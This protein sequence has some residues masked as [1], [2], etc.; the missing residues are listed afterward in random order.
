M[1]IRDFNNYRSFGVIA[2][3]QPMPGIIG[4]MSRGAAN[5]AEN[6]QPGFAAAWGRAKI[7]SNNA[8]ALPNDP[9]AQWAKSESERIEKILIKALYDIDWNWNHDNITH[10]SGDKVAARNAAIKMAWDTMAGGFPAV[11]QYVDEAS[12][13]I[14]ARLDLQAQQTRAQITAQTSTSV[15]AIEQN[16]AT[17]EQAHA[18]AERA[19]ADAFTAEKSAIISQLDVNKLVS[20]AA[21][22]KILGIPVS[23]LALGAVVS[24]GGYFA[25][26]KFGKKKALSGYRRHRRSRR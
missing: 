11:Q 5:D 14:K 16:H 9:E 6:K 2:M 10:S 26:K 17:T 12:A 22:T 1:I 4:T 13:A 23:I 3:D 20:D 19:T 24:V 18:T 21:E 7:I 25:W 8:A 15:V